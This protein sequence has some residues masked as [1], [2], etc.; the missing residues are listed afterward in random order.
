MAPS[1]SWS[2]G[3]VAA[4]L[5]TADSPLA[6]TLGLQGTQGEAYWAA[7]QLSIWLFLEPVL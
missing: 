3:A 7:F 6:A 2:P 4:A 5:G 1:V